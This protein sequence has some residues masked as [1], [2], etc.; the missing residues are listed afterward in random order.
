MKHLYISILKL[1]PAILL[2]TI[3]LIGACSST[4]YEPSSTTPPLA[5]K[6]SNNTSIN[7]R[8]IAEGFNVADGRLYD[9]NGNQFVMRGV[10]YPYAWFPQ[11]DLN[12]Q[13]SDIASTC[14][15]TV[16]VV[17][18]NGEQW[19]RVDGKVVAKI[20]ATAKAHQ[21]VTMLEVHDITG[22][23][24][25]EAAADPQTAIDYWLSDDIRKA[26]EGEEGFVLINIANE[27]FGN[28]SDP[29]LGHDLW[30][31]FHM[32]AVK[33]LRAAGLKHTIV[34]DAP[35]WGQDSHMLMRD[36]KSAQ[37]LF[38]S[39]SD[40]NLIFSVHM[41]QLFGSDK[42]VADYLQTFVG[43][44]FPLIVGEF[45]DDHG[46]EHNVAEQA[47]LS[48]SEKLSIGYLGWSWSGNSEGLG[49]LDIVNYF[50]VNQ[51]SAWGETL[52]NSKNGIR[53]TSVKCS[54]FPHN[55]D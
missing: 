10:N 34:V 12:K 5:C 15:N 6:A 16:R 37:T 14:A 54:C 26:I 50:D 41:Y 43:R 46:P 47:I 7:T 18:A 48:Y 27:P 8:K 39:D 44:K 35:N 21:L 1:K 22:F 45:A 40:K 2:S 24:E 32:D 33:K 53:A 13:F 30:L 42:K 3:L 38:N 49:S 36:G 19:D 51:L 31:E 29:Q 4:A 17:L 25:K 52:I 11:H 28:F 20:I 23:G 9:I 55:D